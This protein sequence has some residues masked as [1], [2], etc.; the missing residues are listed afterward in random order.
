MAAAAEP[1]LVTRRVRVRGLVQG[2]GYRYACVQRA[3]ALG[4]AGWVRNRI[5]GSVEA[6]L[7][8]P[9]AQVDRMCEWMRTGVPGARVDRL[10]AQDVPPPAGRIDGFAQQP[11]A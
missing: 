1:D 6:L 3:E 4:L 8:G 2:V 10:L 7:Q 5:D 9:P 11:T